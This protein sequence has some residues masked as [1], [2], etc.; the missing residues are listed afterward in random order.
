LK[1]SRPFKNGGGMRLDDRRTFERFKLK[2]FLNGY[3]TNSIEKFPLHA[4]DIS[5]EGM[6]IISDKKLPLGSLVS[7]SLQVPGINKELPAQGK[8]IWSEQLEDG[9]RAGLA[10]EQTGCMEVSTVLRFLH[11]K[12]G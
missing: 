9:F 12:P 1:K 3:Y 4:H 2:L 5:A 11:T 7:M 10:L 6:G 8:V